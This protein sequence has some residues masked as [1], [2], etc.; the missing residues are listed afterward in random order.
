MNEWAYVKTYR[1]T[2][3]LMNQV[4]KYMNQVYNGRPMSCTYKGILLHRYRLMDF[5]IALPSK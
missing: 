5:P 3:V 1:P 4:H 2:V